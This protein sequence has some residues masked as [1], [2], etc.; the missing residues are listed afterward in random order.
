M[1]KVLQVLF[2]E[3]DT[4]VWWRVR[5]DPLVLPG[6]WLLMVRVHLLDVL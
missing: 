2:F 4:A 3:L 6:H 5:F 1:Y